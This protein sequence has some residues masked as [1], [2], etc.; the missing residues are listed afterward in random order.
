[1]KTVKGIDGR[2]FFVIS[3]KTTGIT[4]YLADKVP[5]SY[6]HHNKET[7]TYC[8]LEAKKNGMPNCG[9]GAAISF[10]ED[11]EQTRTTLVRLRMFGS[12]L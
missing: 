12:K 7:N 2:K 8:H 3:D 11:N 5:C 9:S 4:C 6:L 1:M 10:Y